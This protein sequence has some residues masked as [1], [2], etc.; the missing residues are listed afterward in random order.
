MRVGVRVRMR[1]FRKG[2][3]VK[4]KREQQ[5]LCVNWFR[6]STQNSTKRYDGVGWLDDSPSFRAPSLLAELA[7]SAYRDTAAQPENCI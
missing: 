7:P 1:V 2:I 6:N 3:R 4:R 5:M